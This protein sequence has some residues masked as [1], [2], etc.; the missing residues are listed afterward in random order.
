MAEAMIGVAITGERKWHA[1]WWEWH[2]LIVLA[3]LII[4]FAV[5]REWRD[6][7]FRGL[8]L[9]STR[10]RRQDM[11][12]LFGDLVGFTSFSERS[13]PAEVAA[14]LNAY[15]GKAA[16]LLTRRFGGEVE[17][18]I[19]DGIVA[20]FNS[21]GD[22]PD[23]ALQASRAALALQRAVEA[24]ANE[25][26]GWPR[27]RIGV[28]SGDAVVREI[29]GDGHVAYTLVGDTINTGSRLEGLAPPGGVLIGANTHAELP[30]GALVEER[31][32]LRMKGKE[33]LVN[34]YVLLALP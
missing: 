8:Y 5:R 10:E 28:N 18:F 24:L 32:G 4:G 33:D 11:S 27:L 3:Y 31:I 29:G 34:A 1:S 17:K 7:R 15:W 19:G 26:P 22:Q 13:S 14:V 25:H 23:H 21:R 20:T 9:P 16:P 2:G 12:V 6:E 30:N